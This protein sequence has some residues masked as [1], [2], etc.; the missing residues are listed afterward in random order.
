MNILLE[1]FIF[2]IIFI[3]FIMA[4]PFI[5]LYIFKYFIN[6]ESKKSLNN[7]DKKK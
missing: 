5:G 7:K 3:I 2:L 4:V 6:K 1:F